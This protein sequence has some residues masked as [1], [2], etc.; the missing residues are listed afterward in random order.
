M[1]FDLQ[2]D[3]RVLT[4]TNYDEEVINQ[5]T[6]SPMLIECVI[7]S[8]NDTKLGENTA[9]QV[10]VIFESGRQLTLFLSDLDI[11]ILQRA[12]GTYILPA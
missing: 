8:Q 12:V 1:D 10:D 3:V 6:L 7:V 5:V 2:E 11:L 4:L 9:K